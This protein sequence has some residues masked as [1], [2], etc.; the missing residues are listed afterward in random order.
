MAGGSLWCG[1]ACA[2]IGRRK[3][4]QGCG[5]HG[6]LRDGTEPFAEQHGGVVLEVAVMV[7]E[8]G[9]YEAA[10][11]FGDGQAGSMV[12]DE[13]VGE[14]GQAEFLVAAPAGLGDAVRVEH[15]TVTGFQLVPAQECGK[16]ESGAHGVG[17]RAVQQGDP[18][19]AADDHRG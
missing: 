18:A 15:Q 11:G 8:N 17:G 10:Q 2:G 19:A 14:A 1:S 16:A 12:A 5:P 3:S 4:G 9:V 6:R 13:E 7:F